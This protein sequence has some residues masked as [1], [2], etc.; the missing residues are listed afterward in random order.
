[1]TARKHL[2]PASLFLGAIVLDVVSKRWA[3][4]ALSPMHV[5]HDVMGSFLR[6]TLAFNRG[7][8]FGM[9]LGEWSRLFFGTV[10][11]L[12]VG[13]LFT[14]Y[15]EAP[16]TERMRRAALALIAGG[17]IGNLIDRL[18]WEG[19]VVDFIDI[20]TATWRFWTFNVADS[21]V[22]VGTILLLWV[23]RDEAPASTTP[24]ADAATGP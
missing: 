17:A 7:A 22:T 4:E 16:D 24:A 20:G 6:F 11:V 12:I 3:V 21:A 2:M 18:R 8:A 5:P 23:M 9:H 13:V 19:G 14:M 1:V 15:R 10:A